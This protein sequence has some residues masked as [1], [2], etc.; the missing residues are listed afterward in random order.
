MF[1]RLIHIKQKLVQD[2]TTRNVILV[3]L[4]TKDFSLFYQ[5]VMVMPMLF[6][7]HAKNVFLLMNM[8]EYH[9]KIKPIGYLGH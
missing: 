7:V 5:L 1:V 2:S 9:V 8:N 4:A 3:V 6:V